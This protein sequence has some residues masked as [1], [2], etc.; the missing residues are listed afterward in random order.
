MQFFNQ[1]TGA[2][3]I[4]NYLTQILSRLGVTGGTPLLLIGESSAEM[5]FAFGPLEDIDMP[6]PYPGIYNL[7]TVPGNLCNGLFIDR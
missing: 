5:G 7:C 1:T 6:S 3:V 4:N 2:L